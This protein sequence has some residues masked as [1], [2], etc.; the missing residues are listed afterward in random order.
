MLQHQHHAIAIIAAMCGPVEGD[1]VVEMEAV[2]DSFHTDLHTAED[3]VRII[4]DNP[5]REFHPVEKWRLY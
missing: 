2:W 3:A 5:R 4:L 1:L